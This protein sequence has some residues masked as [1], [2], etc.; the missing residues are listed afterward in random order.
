MENNQNTKKSWGGNWS[1][2]TADNAIVNFPPYIP[3]PNAP[4]G[5]VQIEYLTKRYGSFVALAD[6]TVQFPRGKVIGLLGPNG[7][8]KTTLIK[9][10]TNLLM[11]YDGTI[12]I[13]GKKPGQETKKI[14]SYL[15]DRN[16]LPD[17]WSTKHA[18]NYFKDF[19]PDFDADKAHRL[20]GDLFIDTD[21][22]FKTLSKGTKEKVQLVLVLSRQ[23]QLYIFD[24]PIAGVD[25]A[26]RDYIFRMIYNNCSR[27][28]SV[29]ISTHLVSEAETIF[30][31]A[32]FLKQGRIVL[33]GEADDIRKH[34]AR[35]LNDLFREVYRYA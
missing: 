14:V 1:A 2:V 25:P 32:V 35:S 28:S 30:D 31:H 11:Q 17:N 29:I 9:L 5:L 13:D 26:A 16:Y 24:E 23:A 10:L 27:E 18:I 20:M 33:A 21:K 4:P 15:P 3:N 8:G 19:Y 22:R 34:Y 7:S 6:V 12:L